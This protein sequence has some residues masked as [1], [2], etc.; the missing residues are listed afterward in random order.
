MHV[1]RTGPVLELVRPYS[2]GEL[3]DRKAR[4]P[5]ILVSA[6]GANQE[7]DEWLDSDPDFRSVTIWKSCG[8]HYVRL[9]F[10]E[11]PGMTIGSS[12]RSREFAK[13]LALQSA[14][15]VGAR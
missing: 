12:S 4:T 2:D 10:D 8:K 5:V 6:S 11:G 3:S 14:R 9:D 15:K 1:D 13:A 7:L